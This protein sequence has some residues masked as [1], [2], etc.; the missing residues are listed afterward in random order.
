MISLSDKEW[1]KRLKPEQYK[2]LRQ[3]DTEPPFSGKFD[4]FWR[5]GEY[6]CAG[7]GK[8]LF[9]SDYKYDAGCGWPSFWTAVNQAGIKLVPDNSYGMERTEVVCGNCNGHLGPLFDDGPKEHGGKRYC[10]NST[11]L[12]FNLNKSDD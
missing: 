10:I 3:K 1:Q 5:K 11:A 8:T 12:E 4:D 6:K 7:C 2:V 9:K